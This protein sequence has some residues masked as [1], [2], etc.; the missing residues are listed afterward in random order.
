MRT[1]EDVIVQHLHLK[2]EMPGTYVCR[3][4]NTCVADSSCGELKFGSDRRG[5]LEAAIIASFILTGGPVDVIT[6]M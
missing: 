3:F 2:L 4:A 1:F 6:Y 5:I